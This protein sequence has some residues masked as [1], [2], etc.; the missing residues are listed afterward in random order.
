M[1]QEAPAYLAVHPAGEEGECRPVLGRQAERRPAE[2]AV[3]EVHLR[4]RRVLPGPEALRRVGVAQNPDGVAVELPVPLRDQRR[5]V[6]ARHE[7]VVGAAGPV[8]VRV[9]LGDDVDVVRDQAA[10]RREVGGG[11]EAVD[12]VDEVAHADGKQEDVGLDGAARGE[13]VPGVLYLVQ[14]LALDGVDVGARQPGPR[15]AS[16]GS[17]SWYVHIFILLSIST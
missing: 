11:V 15:C 6:V 12:V 13:A 4:Q 10:Q 14:E 7:D 16:G 3:G 17:P 8:P 1:L 5:P 2:D 9:P